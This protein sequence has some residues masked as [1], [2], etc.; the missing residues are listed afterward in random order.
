M[1]DPPD[2]LGQYSIM[3]IEEITRAVMT[4]PLPQ[5][6]ALAGFLLESAGAAPDP[7]AE[8]TWEAEISDR[9]RAIDEGRIRGIPYEDVMRDAATRLAP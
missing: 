3:A 1:F 6:L 2:R 5:R 4:L 9:L 8:A 7:E